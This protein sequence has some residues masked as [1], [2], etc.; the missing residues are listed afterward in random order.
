MTSDVKRVE[1]KTKRQYFYAELSRHSKGEPGA[2]LYVIDFAIDW[3][4]KPWIKYRL[5]YIKCFDPNI[6]H[7]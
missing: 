6:V 2:Q 4:I 3:E 1:M 7:K 5:K